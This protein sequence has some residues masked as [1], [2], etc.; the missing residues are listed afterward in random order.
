MVLLPAGMWEKSSE[1]YRLMV[2]ALMEKLNVECLTFEWPGRGGSPLSQ[3]PLGF[4]QYEAILR[5]LVRQYTVSGRQVVVIGH[6]LGGLLAQSAA[7]GNPDIVAFVAIASAQAR[8]MAPA[9]Q[10]V[11]EML[12][13]PGILAKVCSDGQFYLPYES[14]VRLGLNCT[15]EEH[16]RRFVQEVGSESGRVARDVIMGIGV[17]PQTP[18]TTAKPCFIGFSEDKFCPPRIQIET[19]TKWGVRPYL[20][21]GDHIGRLIDPV[22]AFAL[23]QTVLRFLRE[24][25][26]I[27]KLDLRF[28]QA[29]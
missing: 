28:A 20:F 26:K 27:S 11:L 12:R 14:L 29:A 21:D 13:R 10:V 23:N 9:P 8:G 6:S 18:S 15:H 24:E 1:V 2:E 4:R 17:D 5:E 3:K 19:A 25:V 22:Q 7:I 16:I